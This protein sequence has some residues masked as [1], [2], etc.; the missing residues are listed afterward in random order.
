M[1][2]GGA[3]PVTYRGSTA[4]SLLK[5]EWDYPVYTPPEDKRAEG[6]SAR[7]IRRALGR[8][9]ALQFIAGDDPRP[10]LVLRE[11]KVC[12]GT[13]S[14]LLKG[15]IE[16]E[17]TFLLASWYHCVKL[18]ADVLE[19]D[20][21]FHGLFVKAQPEH[22]FVS[23][24]DGSNHDPLESQTSR[25]ELWKAMRGLLGKE[26]KRKPDSSVKKIARILDRMDGADAR[27]NR[28]SERR[29]DVLERDGPRSK[30]LKKIVAEIDEVI[31]ERLKLRREAVLASKLEL[32]APK[33]DR[34]AEAAR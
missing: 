6:S 14:A 29:D 25:T 16:N 10:L 11:C 31:A 20:H 32:K 5:I 12:N 34:Q 28:L 30:K 19:Q 1:A 18:P 3:P 23:S 26:Y 8:E 15:G 2:S 7:R 21:P 24:L 13:D 4:K 17:Q 9:D 27:F 22:L 33:P